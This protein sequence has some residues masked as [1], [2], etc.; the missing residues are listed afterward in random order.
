MAFVLAAACLAYAAAAHAAP[1]QTLPGPGKTVPVPHAVLF[2]RGVE[3]YD[4]GDYKTAFD[5]WLPLAQKGDPAAM[6]NTAHLLRKGQ[7]TARNPARALYFYEEAARMGLP[8]A[9]LN[10]AFMNLQGDGVPENLEA[11]AFWFH[12]ASLQGSP[13]AQYNL[14]VMYER[15]LGVKRDISQARAWYALAARSG[16]KLA[17][18]RLAAL[19]PDREDPP[20]APAG[21]E[22]PGAADAAP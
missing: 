21:F 2:E 4:R 3:A 12:A 9:Q 20:P 1:V 22:L 14:A 17:L 18:D 5:I 11:A 16:H 15:G 7:G 8:A 10:T 13:V 19:A 6:R